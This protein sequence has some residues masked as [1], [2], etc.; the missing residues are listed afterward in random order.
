MEQAYH[1]AVTNRP[2]C[3]G[4]PDEVPVQA[5]KK[6][7]V[8]VANPFAVRQGAPASRYANTDS[9]TQI[10]EA[11]GALSHGSTADAMRDIAGIIGL[12]RQKGFR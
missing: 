7:R 8:E 9:I 2:G 11:Y 5:S 3:H 4:V 12:Q 10:H 6:A 1:A